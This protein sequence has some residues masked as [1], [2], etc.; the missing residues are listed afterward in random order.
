MGS[1]S[2]NSITQEF[3]FVEQ[4]VVGYSQNICATITSMGWLLYLVEYTVLM[5]FLPK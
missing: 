1:W 2:G 4:K 3:Y 5:T